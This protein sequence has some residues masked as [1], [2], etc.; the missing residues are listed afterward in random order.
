VA[1]MHR[2]ASLV[3]PPASLA[4]VAGQDYLAMPADFGSIVAVGPGSLR[5][6]LWLTTIDYVVQL[7]QNGQS[8]STAFWGALV[9]PGQASASQAPPAARLALYPTP[10]TTTADAF[11]LTYRAGWTAL[12]ADT[13]V[14]NLPEFF[15]PLLVEM[16]SAFAKS[17]EE[18]DPA[19]RQATIAAIKAGPVFAAVV[20][21]DGSRQA[22][23]GPMRGGA[24][25]LG[26]TLNRPW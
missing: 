3:R 13:D 11:T 2:W 16:V 7:R 4:T 19:V 6:P 9:Q 5:R 22:H 20:A 8:E 10:S 17:R 14:A 15:E 1:S 23:C 25:S 26:A 18:M 24:A 12:S 21:E